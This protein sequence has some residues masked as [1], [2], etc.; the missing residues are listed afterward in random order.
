MIPAKYLEMILSILI[1]ILIEIFFYILQKMVYK[2]A[3]EKR[4][5]KSWRIGFVHDLLY[6]EDH[7]K[8]HESKSDPNQKTGF[9]PKE[10]PTSEKDKDLDGPDSPDLVD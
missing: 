3:Q 8:D 1:A 10:E 9:Y 2:A 5:E 4:E 7:I 6:L